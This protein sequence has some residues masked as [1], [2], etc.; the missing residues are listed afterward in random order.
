MTIS[1]PRLPHQNF[2]TVSMGSN[3]GYTL[4]WNGLIVT[5]YILT[6]YDIINRSVTQIIL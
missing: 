6:R 2:K 5:L 3:Y 1:F 4:V